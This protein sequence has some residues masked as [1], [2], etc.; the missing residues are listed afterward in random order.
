MISNIIALC[1][2][3][4]NSDNFRWKGEKRLSK[5]VISELTSEGREGPR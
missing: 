4:E 1:A 5:L 3:A 2:E